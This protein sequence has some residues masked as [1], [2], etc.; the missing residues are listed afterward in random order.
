MQRWL[1]A[2]PILLF[3]LLID[4]PLPEMRLL[5]FLIGPRD[6]LSFVTD[7][8]LPGFTLDFFMN[9]SDRCRQLYAVTKPEA[10]TLGPCPW[11]AWHETQV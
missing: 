6:D 9:F 2:C 5:P 7:F 4:A 10:G 1:V 8:R 11:S 3:D